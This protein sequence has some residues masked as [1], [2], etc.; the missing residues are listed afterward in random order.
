MRCHALATGVRAN[1]ARRWQPR[2]EKMRVRT[3]KLT[4]P[5]FSTTCVMFSVNSS[6]LRSYMRQ[7]KEYE[8]I[9]DAAKNCGAEF[10]IFIGPNK[11][12]IYPEYLPPVIV[13]GQRRFIAPLL[14]TLNDAGIKAYDPTA[15]LIAKKMK[16][17]SI[18][19]QIPTGTLRERMKHLKV[20]ENGL[21]FPLYPLFPLPEFPNTMVTW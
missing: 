13:P 20:S 2:R 10:F 16:V 8:E 9:H 21:C 4:V 18:T 7:T 17:F 14:D 12:S 19:G 6:A 3:V 1:I 5:R 15:R 11:S